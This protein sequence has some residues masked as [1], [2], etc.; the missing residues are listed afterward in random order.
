MEWVGYLTQ[1]GSVHPCVGG[2]ITNPSKFYLNRIITWDELEMAQV[3]LNDFFEKPSSQPSAFGTKVSPPN[4]DDS[5]YF[6]DDTKLTPGLYIAVLARIGGKPEWH[7]GLILDK[8]KGKKYKVMLIDYGDEY[9]FSVKDIRSL[10]E[11]FLKFPAQAVRCKLDFGNELNSLHSWNGIWTKAEGRQFL[12]VIKGHDLQ[13]QFLSYEV[14]K[15]LV[16][17]IIWLVKMNKLISKEGVKTAKDERVD[18]ELVKVLGVNWMEQCKQ[19]IEMNQQT[20]VPGMAPTPT[21]EQDRSTAADEIDSTS[22]PLSLSEADYDID[23]LGDYEDDD[24]N[25]SL[26]DFKGLLVPKGASTKE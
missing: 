9:S 20:G 14:D 8:L 24:I 17:P 5:H 2:L 7:R 13:V 21:Y 1:L 11:Q 22:I 6:P 15:N 12:E 10:P 3:A 16:N 25:V 26:V 18:E 4:K 23:I 19:R